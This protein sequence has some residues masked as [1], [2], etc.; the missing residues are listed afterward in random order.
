MKVL[1]TKVLST[2][3]KAHPDVRGSVKAWKAEVKEADWERPIDIK[4]RYVS[5]SFLKENV[6]IFN[7]RGKRYRL[8]VKVDY[9]NKMLLVKKAGTHAEYSRWKL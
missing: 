9:R 5:A 3:M 6:V 4:R 8:V 1:G 7:I 2:F